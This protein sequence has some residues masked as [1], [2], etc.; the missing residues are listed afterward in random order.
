MYFKREIESQLLNQLDKKEVLVITGMRRTGKTTILKYLFSQIDSK[1]KVLL[2]LQ[3]ILEQKIFDEIDFNNI[4]DNLKFYSINKDKKIYIF[5][6]EI[7]F[8]PKVTN[9]IKYLYDHYNIKFVVTGSSSFYLKNYFPESLAGR[10]VIFELYPLNFREFLIFK[11]VKCEF[12][13]S[14]VEKANSKNRIVYE[15]LKNYYSEYLKFG[16]FP[17]VVLENDINQKKNILKDI[18]NSYF[19][20]DILSLS[21][22]K[23]I[24]SL[25]KLIFLLLERVGSKLDITKLASLTG[26]SRDSIYT[27][28]NLLEGSY[29][30]YLISPFTTNKDREVSGTK[31]I[32]ICDTGILNL[33][34]QVSHG[35]ILENAVFMN[36]LKYG[37]INYFQKR[38]GIEIDFIVNNS[39]ALEVKTTG[40]VSDI[41]KIK[42]IA[43]QI[44]LDDY[45]LIS[46]NYIDE[47]EA[48]CAY[49]V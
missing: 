39:L 5:I 2:D 38:N 48:I 3:N 16:G 12:L 46:E 10:K 14:F 28:L 37:T 40:D 29:F 33:I 31:K 42:R 6:D 19:Q 8:M 25:K 24:D 20:I 17:Q 1:N 22:F 49:Q 13:E 11:D 7:Q 15:K 32:F 41:K 47:K 34:S 30:I 27:Y 36:L 23:K 35:N 18:F 21:D 44:N 43:S 26:V 9:A 45:F 4:L